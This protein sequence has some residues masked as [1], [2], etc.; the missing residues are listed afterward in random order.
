MTYFANRF[1][2]QKHLPALNAVSLSFAKTSQVAVMNIDGLRT[3]SYLLLYLSQEEYCT[4]HREE[5]FIQK[6]EDNFVIDS[7]THSY[8]P[9]NEG[10]VSLLLYC[11]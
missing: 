7:L 11:T 10:K 4:V 9:K 5:N 1:S 8:N 2:E 3:Y 6:S